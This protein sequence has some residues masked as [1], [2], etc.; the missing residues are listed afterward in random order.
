MY[1]VVKQSCNRVGSSGSSGSTRSRFVLVSRV[2]PASKL[3]GSGSRANRLINWRCVHVVVSYSFFVSHTHLL[4]VLC[5]VINCYCKNNLFVWATPTL[6]VKSTVYLY[7]VSRIRCAVGIHRAMPTYR[8]LL[9]PANCKL[10]WNL[11]CWLIVDF[12]YLPTWLS[13]CVLR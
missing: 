3:S 13:A 4:S 6:Y 2:W 10:T 7:I 1:R 9:P 11:T 12:T 8:V 5:N